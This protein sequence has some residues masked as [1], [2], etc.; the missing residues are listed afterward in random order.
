[1]LLDEH[2][3]TAI[4]DDKREAGE[5]LKKLKFVGTLRKTN[6]LQ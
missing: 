1:M 3:I 4:I 2:K 6:P 5:R